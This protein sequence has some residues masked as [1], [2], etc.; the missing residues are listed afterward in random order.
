MDRHAE[1]VEIRWEA[2]YR[3]GRKARFPIAA[4]IAQ[5][6]HGAVLRR[7]EMLRGKIPCGEIVEVI[8]VEVV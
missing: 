3:G 5:R 7:A 4:K 2:I 8:L 1:W 6:A